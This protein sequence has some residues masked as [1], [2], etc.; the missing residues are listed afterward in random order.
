MMIIN[1]AADAIG[2]RKWLNDFRVHACVRADKMH[3]F[4]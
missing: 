1:I 3:K 2:P 4:T